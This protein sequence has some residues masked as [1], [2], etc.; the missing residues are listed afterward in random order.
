MKA[1]RRPSGDHTG[2]RSAEDPPTSVVSP[3][4]HGW[5][6]SMSRL[7][8]VFEVNAMSPSPPGT[9]ALTRP[10]PSA[11]KRTI[12]SASVARRAPRRLA[13]PISNN[14]SRSLSPPCGNTILPVEPED[15]DG[16]RSKELR[17]DVVTEGHLWQLAEDAVERQ[18]HREVTGVQHLVGAAGVGVV[19]DGPRVVL[20][21]E[22][23]GG[24]VEVR[25]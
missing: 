3:D 7:P 2:L 21:G 25:P 14:R 11:G 12:V 15:P 4:P 23:T 20:R 19:D 16:V 17:P 8:P 13:S 1:I 22:R 6:A 9:T 18:A 24:V 5:I 10:A